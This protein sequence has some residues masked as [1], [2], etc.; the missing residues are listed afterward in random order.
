MSDVAHAQASNAAPGA[1]GGSP[2]ARLPAWAWV[3]VLGAVLLLPRLGGFGLWDPYEIK[4]ADQATRV[5]RGAPLPAGHPPLGAL[6]TAMGVRLWGSSELSGRLPQALCGLL[7]L[8]A[9]WYAASGLGSGRA[10]LL[11]AALLSVTPLHLL[12]ARSMASDA[13]CAAALALALGGLGRWYVDGRGRDLALGLVGTGLATLGAGAVGGCL[14]AL[15]AAVCLTLTGGQSALRKAMG[16]AAAAAGLAALAAFPG[17][18]PTRLLGAAWL[19][20]PAAVTFEEGIKWIGWSFF[21]WTPLAALAVGAAT[22]RRCG[23]GDA[24]RA[25]GKRFALAF[26][27]L[28]CAAYT[29]QAARTMGELRFAG[30]GALAVLTALLGDELMADGLAHPLLGVAAGGG[31]LLMARDLFLFPEEFGAAHVRET[32]RWP[33]EV[34]IGVPLLVLSAAVA[35]PLGAA[36]LVKQPAR[37]TQLALAAFAGAA[38]LALWNA[39][40]VTMQLSHHLSWKSVFDRYSALAK[41]GEPLRT[42]GTAGHGLAYY[43]GREPE[44][45]NQANE[46]VR[47]FAQSACVYAIAPGEELGAIDQ[48]VRAAGGRYYVADDSTSRYMLLSNCL[49]PGET[50]RNPLLTMVSQSPPS[51]PPAHPVQADWEDKV[52]LIGVDYPAHVS[53]VTEGKFDITL[54]LHVKQHMPPG[55]RIFLHFDGCQSRVNGDHAPLG[56]KLQSQFWSPGDYIRDTVTVPVPLMTTVA[57]AYAIYGGIYSGDARLKLSPGSAA[58][59]GG[60]QRVPLG[61]IVVR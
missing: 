23:D 47:Y 19:G 54:Y 4:Y 12:G 61:T 34:H 51:P 30:A 44:P 55:Y 38:L 53:R 46:L 3:L 45:I 29:F 22:L 7:A 26:A 56:G 33:P 11:A 39:Q 36:L 52:E 40:I 43:A 1:V 28:T 27:T 18:W 13:A 31:V 37:R 41:S 48:M 24:A 42:Y 20:G 21:P 58:E 32:M 50:D 59:P 10:G 49:V 8:L 6:V 57:C 15:G 5:A 35:V 60:T 17:P 16:V 9:V 25:D 14:P 2:I